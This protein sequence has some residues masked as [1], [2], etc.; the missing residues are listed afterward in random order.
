MKAIMVMF[1]SLNRNY[2]P[3]YGNDWVKAPNF[4]RLAEKSVTFERF[5]AGSM[6]CM[7]ARRELHTGRYNFMH[8]S[9]GPLEPFDVS[10]PEILKKNGVYTHLITD[11][12]HYFED[13]GATYHNRYNTYEFVRGQQGDNCCG[14]VADPKIPECENPRK[15]NLDNWRQDWVNRSFMDSEE[16]QPMPMNFDLGLD[17]IDRNKNEDNWF[18]QLETF[19]PHEPFYTMEKYKD[20]YDRDYKG[21]HYDWPNYGKVD[22]PEATVEH[23]R[24]EYAALVTM[25]DVYLGKVLDMMDQHNLWED[26]MLIVNT[27]HGFMLGEKEWYG[28]N[29]QPF[30]N[31]IIHTPF[32]MYDPRNPSQGEQRQAI[33]QTIDIAPTLLSYF[34]QEVPDTMEGSSLEAVI[35]NDQKIRDAALFGI[36]G[37]HVNVVDENYV[38]MRANITPDNGPLNEYTLMPTRMRDMFAP[39]EFDEATMTGKEDFAFIGCPVMKI[40]TQSFLQSSTY[41]HLLFDLKKDPHQNEPIENL[42]IELDMAKK[43]IDLMVINEAPD[44]QFTRLGYEKKSEI[45]ADDLHIVIE[46]DSSQLDRDT[47][48]GVL[49]KNKQAKAVL[50]KY[51]GK[52]MKNPMFRMAH[53]LSLSKLQSMAADKMPI[54]LVDQIEKDLKALKL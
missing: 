29:I 33:C 48:I 41:G 49:L 7:P 3:C 16:K 13:G 17:F 20:L 4:E 27:D 51:L 10:M 52:H 32:F 12:F 34:G 31:E 40:P 46:A 38:Y 23:I 21:N 18:L 25:C 2:L 39:S 14:M 19:D 45:T 53:G 1:D 37:G 11:H 43:M 22:D 35:N 42:D 36:H 15:F 44:E 6:P 30:Y 54:E 5:Y 47:P 24:K 9:W 26:T 50:K 8:R 28:K